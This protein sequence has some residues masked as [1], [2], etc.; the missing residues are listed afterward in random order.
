M[1]DLFIPL[2]RWSGPFVGFWFGGCLFDA[3]GV[4]LGWEDTQGRVWRREGTY[5]GQRMHGNYIMR[6]EGFPQPVRQP[7]R[8]PPVIPDLPAPPTARTARPPV[9]GWTDALAQI[10]LR[11][12]AADLAGTWHNQTERIQLKDDGTYLLLSRHAQPQIG[13]WELRTN[14]IMTPLVPTAGGPARLVFHIIE[15]EGHSLNLRRVTQDE[16]SIPLTL[17]RLPAGAD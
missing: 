8:V 3:N 15:Y 9:P 17:H 10:G 11:P 5:L 14:L 4:Y 7:R 2:F 6:R 16:R 13:R 1:E 12:D